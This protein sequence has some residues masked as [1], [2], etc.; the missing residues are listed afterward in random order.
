MTPQ[1]WDAHE[2]KYCNRCHYRRK[3]SAKSVM[4]QHPN[5]KQANRIFDRLGYCSQYDYD[6][7]AEKSANAKKKTRHKR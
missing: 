5:D 4:R 7:R 1:E 3:C 6:Q 2:K